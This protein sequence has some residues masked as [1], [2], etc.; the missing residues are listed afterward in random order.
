MANRGDV[1]TFARLGTDPQIAKALQ[2]EMAKAIFAEWSETNSHEDWD[3]L[4]ADKD[5][6]ERFFVLLAEVL[7]R[8]LE[9]QDLNE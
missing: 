7:D 1:L 8:E 2:V 9:I 6:L 5:N 4:R 3:R